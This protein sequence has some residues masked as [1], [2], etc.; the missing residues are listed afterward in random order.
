MEGHVL[1]GWGDVVR[2]VRLNLEEGV[3]FVGGG[4]HLG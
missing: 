3:L 2:V 1:K 4:H